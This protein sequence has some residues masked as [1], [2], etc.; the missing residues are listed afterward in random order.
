MTLLVYF[1]K[2]HVYHLAYCPPPPKGSSQLLGEL[3][4]TLLR[5]QAEKK[6]TQQQVLTK[7]QHA[8]GQRSPQTSSLLYDG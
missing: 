7:Q 4:A 5:I 8:Q 2:V 3:R 6:D 1:F